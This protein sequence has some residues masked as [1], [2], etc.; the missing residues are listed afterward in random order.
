MFRESRLKLRIYLFWVN[1]RKFNTPKLITYIMNRRR[2]IGLLLLFII[3]SDSIAKVAHRC[4][5]DEILKGFKP[6]K[7]KISNFEKK[8]RQYARQNVSPIKIVLD[9][10]NLK[11][12]GQEREFKISIMGKWFLHLKTKK[13]KVFL[14][15]FFFLLFLNFFLFLYGAR[16]LNRLFIK[17]D[18]CF[19][20][21]QKHC[22]T[23]VSPFL[24]VSACPWSSPLIWF[25]RRLSN[26]RDQR[27]WTNGL[28]LCVGG[29]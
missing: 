18:K 22:F 23:A 26:L 29:K 7:I 4:K 25:R 19:K 10:S 20:H 11:S 27:P 12:T 6:T 9:T 28:L 24:Q 16:V 5:H 13:K 1:S 2:F 14:Y 8:Y 17:E 15:V 21:R 3:S